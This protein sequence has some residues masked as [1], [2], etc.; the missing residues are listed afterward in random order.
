MMKMIGRKRTSARD[1]SMKSR[2]TL[3]SS[4]RS[5]DSVFQ[6][7]ETGRNTVRTTRRTASW[8][9]LHARPIAFFGGLAVGWVISLIAMTGLGVVT[10]QWLSGIAVSNNLH[11]LDAWFATIR[12]HNSIFTG[13]LIYF[14][15][16]TWLLIPA[17]VVGTISMVSLGNQAAKVVA[18]LDDSAMQT[19]ANDAWIWSVKEM[20]EQY[21]VIAD[22][23]MHTRS[24]PVSSLVGHIYLKNKGLKH[25]MMAKHDKTGAIIYDENGE[26]VREKVPMIDDANIRQTLDTQGLRELDLADMQIDATKY[27]YDEKDGKVRT[28]AQ[29]INEDWYMPDYEFLRPMGAYFVE[30]NSVHTLILSMTRGN[31]T[32]LVTLATVDAWRRDNTLWNLLVND[33]KGGARRFLV[34]S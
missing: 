11:E 30:T 5:R 23:G 27:D 15:G 29:A 14:A 17:V 34:K 9:E 16:R 31:K 10:A 22:L 8:Y 1:F 24:V 13:S 26:V 6:D 28:L 12:A 20:I 33:P 2:N 3:T 32:Q 7:D 18:K 21:A 19:D 25:I 4:A